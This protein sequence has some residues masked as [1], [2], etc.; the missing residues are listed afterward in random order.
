MKIFE[1][2]RF[3]VNAYEDGYLEFIGRHE[4]MILAETAI[5]AALA[6][7]D[8][9]KNTELLRVVSDGKPRELDECE[10]NHCAYLKHVYCRGDHGWFEISDPFRVLNIP[11]DTIVQ[12]VRLERWEGRDNG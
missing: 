11:G 2:G 9:Y 7:L 12:P 3:C 5:S 4:V 8:H 6:I 1:K 10:S